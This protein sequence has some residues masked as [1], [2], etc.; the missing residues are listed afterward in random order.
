M[1]KLLFALRPTPFAAMRKYPYALRSVP[2]AISRKHLFASGYWLFAA[3]RNRPY[4]ISHTPYP[5]S[6]RALRASRSA[7]TL[8]ELLVAI[9]LFSILI[10]IA[11]G[12]FVNTLRTQREAAA[13]MA[14][15]SNVSIA[16]EQMT[17]EIRTGYLFCNDADVNG[18]PVAACSNPNSQF[19]AMPPF[20]G[21][22]CTV[23]AVSQTWTCQNF[24]E[25]YNADS[26]KVDY[27][28]LNGVVERSVDGGTPEAI[29]GDNVTV[30]YLTFVL[31]GNT[32]GDHW[33]PRITIA[34]GVAPNDATVNWNTAN[35]ETSVSA[36]QI[37]CTSAGQC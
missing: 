13:M 36:R 31:F 5:R 30:P 4:P 14:A 33:N 3:L 7:F 10:A 34:V 21:S 20:P 17:R 6:S 1:R 37:D 35:L 11:T 28:L 29:T 24:L 22:G 12:G 16:L 9:A 26:Q 18:N 2:F 32:E 19:A 27:L 8:V 23:D 15:Q 25:F